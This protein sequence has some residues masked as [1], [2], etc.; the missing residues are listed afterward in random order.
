[1]DEK[2]ASGEQRL[3]KDL[4]LSRNKCTNARSQRTFDAASEFCANLLGAST[5]ITTELLRA[6]DEVDIGDICFVA[7]GSVGRDEALQASDLDLI[8]V[9]ASDE[10]LGRYQPHDAFVRG[11]LS[12]KLRIKVSAGSDLTKAISVDS[13][14]DPETIGGDKDDS[15]ALTQ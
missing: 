11:A 6:I 14:A 1:M 9:C 4:I 12:E 3:E 5:R 7:A 8:P 2:P 15:S 13:L 10:V